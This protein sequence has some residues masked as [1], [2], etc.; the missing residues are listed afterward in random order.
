MV[1]SM[2]EEL[3]LTFYKGFFYV[4]SNELI[5]ELISNVPFISETYYIANAHIKVSHLESELQIENDD[6]GTWKDYVKE[7]WIGTIGDIKRERN[8]GLLSGNIMEINMKSSL[9]TVLIPMK[10][11]GMISKMTL[12]ALLKKKLK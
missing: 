6:M 8:V 7:N 4:I 11:F 1:I 5:L 12:M 3:L 9:D 2:C 10:K